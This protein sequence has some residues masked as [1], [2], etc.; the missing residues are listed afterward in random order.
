MPSSARW[1]GNA[2]YGSVIHPSWNLVGTP[3][4]ALRAAGATASL[5]N[6][7]RRVILGK[8]TNLNV[9]VMH[10]PAFRLQADV[11]LRRLGVVALV[12]ELAVQADCHLSI[13]TCDLI[14]VPVAEQ[15]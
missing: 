3:A 1:S 2:A 15:R 10:F 14:A 11:S 5:F 6:T 4:A 8:L 9:A 12:D 7:S 13:L